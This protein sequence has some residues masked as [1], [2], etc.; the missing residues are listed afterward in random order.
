MRWEGCSEIKGFYLLSNEHQV[1]SG[2]SI[3]PKPKE[4]L[5]KCQCKAEGGHRPHLT[6]KMEWRGVGGR[7]GRGGVSVDISVVSKQA[8]T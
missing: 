5:V 1:C 4:Q 8:V 3:F 2:C 7:W 6:D